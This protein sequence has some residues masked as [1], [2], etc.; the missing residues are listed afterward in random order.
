MRRKPPATSHKPQGVSKTGFTWWLVAGG[1]WLCRRSLRVSHASA[2][3]G[4]AS[5]VEYVLLLGG[6]GLPIMYL[7][8]LLLDVLVANY[9]IMTYWITLPFP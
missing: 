8:W 9:R 5:A 2:G 1:R 6:V 3:E 7:V 4:G